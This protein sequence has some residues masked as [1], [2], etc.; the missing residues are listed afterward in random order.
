MPS[1]ST[2]L[3]RKERQ[4]AA[5][6]RRKALSDR[7]MATLIRTIRWRHDHG[8]KPYTVKEAISAVLKE[9]ESEILSIAPQDRDENFRAWKEFLS[10]VEKYAVKSN[11]GTPGTGEIAGG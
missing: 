3:S 6:A 1:D 7:W 11:P 8:L 10:T 5:T 4:E 2:K 9:H